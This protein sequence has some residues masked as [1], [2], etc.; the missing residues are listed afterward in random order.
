MVELVSKRYVK[1]LMIGRDNA[2]LTTLCEQ[3]K[4]I[5][6]AYSDEKFLAI[7][8]SS[9]IKASQKVELVLSFL[10]GEV[11]NE[12]TNFI[13][14]LG[15]KTRLDIIPD[16]VESLES[17]LAVLNNSYTGVIYTNKELSVDDIEKL[18]SQFATKFSV[19]LNLEQKVCDYDGIKVDIDGLGCEIAFSK[20]RLKSQ[21]IEH[22]LKAV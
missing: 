2:S 19:E 9:D 11:S 18:R 7:L 15:E 20:E 3:L 10:E 22:I 17:E 8:S 1:A 5:A 13:K 14:L 16:I 4:K 21:M 12:L 6:A